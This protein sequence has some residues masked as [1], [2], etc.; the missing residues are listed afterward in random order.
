[1]QYMQHPIFESIDWEAIERADPKAGLP[2]LATGR[3]NAHM[4]MLQLVLD[5]VLNL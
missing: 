5:L 2:E 4:T 1:M 3:K